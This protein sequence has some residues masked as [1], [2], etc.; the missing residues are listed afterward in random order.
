MIIN[1]IADDSPCLTDKCA[2]SS[3][4]GLQLPSAELTGYLPGIEPRVHFQNC[5]CSALSNPWLR[6]KLRLKPRTSSLIAYARTTQS[7]Q[8]VEEQLAI[9][10]KYC[11]KHGYHISRVFVDTGG[12]GAGL[13]QALESLNE[14]AG[15]IAVDTDR[16]VA[17]SV[18]RLRALRPLVHHFLCHTD[19][20]LITVEEGI[21]THSPAGQIVAL[22]LL[23]DSKDCF[24]RS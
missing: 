14:A 13:Q 11:H 10:E 7:S 5:R 6:N 2:S 18:D 22:E 8:T 24:R 3:R 16:F 20:H 15:L 1:L 4:G 23:T 19:K 9:L 17:D 12:P 21:D